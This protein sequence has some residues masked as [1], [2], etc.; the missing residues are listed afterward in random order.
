MP[1]YETQV[2]GKT[3]QVELTK[4]GQNAFAGKIDGKSCKI[5]L[6]TDRIKPEQALTIR[7]EEKSYKVKLPKIEQGRII[8]VG[9]EEATFKVEVKTPN[10]KQVLTS[11]EPAPAS[12]ARKAAASKQATAEG[13]ITAPMTGKIVSVKVRKG[14]IVQANQVLCI[15][16]A[17][18]MENE[19]VAL[20]AGMIEQ[21]NIQ[22]GQP[23]SEGETLFVVA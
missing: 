15:I 6:E 14:D 10:R 4:T 13:A 2:D 23:V 12:P 21:V 17:M 8:T 18:K 16:E 20:K 9:V 7:I 11:F 1:S 19:I 22:D 3:H 5:Q